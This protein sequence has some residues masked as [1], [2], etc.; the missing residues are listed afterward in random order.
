MPQLAQSLRLGL[1]RL[2]TLPSTYIRVVINVTNVQRCYLE[3]MGMLRYMTMYKPRMEDPTAEPGLPDDCV[4]VFTSD[5][6]VAQQFRIARLPYWLIRPLSTF[7]HE[8]ILSVVT[9]QETIGQIELEAAPGYPPVSVGFNLDDRMRS[10]HL[11]TQSTAWYKDPFKQPVPSA[12]QAVPSSSHSVPSSSLQ[13]VPPSREPVK[14][15]KDRPSPC[16]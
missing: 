4:G 5:P 3:L 13:T 8:N 9:P 11:C 10:L 12:Q 2:R 1:E 7:L 16:K 15:T 6:I 14:R